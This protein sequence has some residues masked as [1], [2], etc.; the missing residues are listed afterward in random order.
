MDIYLCNCLKVT[1]EFIKYNFK[2]KGHNFVE[3]SSIEQ[4]INNLKC[5]NEATLIIIG[6]DDLD[7]EFIYRIRSIRSNIVI[8]SLFDKLEPKR[9]SSFINTNIIDFID[10]LPLDSTESIEEG[11]KKVLSI[12]YKNKKDDTLNNV[13]QWIKHEGYAEF[14]DMMILKYVYDLIYGYVSGIDAINDITYMLGLKKIP[15]IV[16]TLMVDDF[17]DICINLNNKQRYYTKRT[18]LNLVKKATIDYNSIACS[19]IG[20]EKLIILLDLSDYPREFIQ[21]TIIKISN[22]IKNYIKTN[23]NYTVTLGISNVHDDYKDIWRAYEESFQAINFSFGIGKDIIVQYKD[24]K[25]LQTAKSLNYDFADLEF[26]FFKNLSRNDTKI[27]LE[28]YDR[29]F[30]SLTNK[31]YTKDIIKS[32]LNKFIYNVLQYYIELGLDQKFIS[33]IAMET[34]IHISGASSITSIKEIGRRLLDE[35]SKKNLELTK[36]NIDVSLNAA[37]IFINKYYYKSITLIDVSYV[38]NM[39]AS[40]FSRK[41]KGRYG[42]NFV[43]YLQKIRLE[44]AKELLVES[45]LSIKEVADKVGFNDVAYFSK[46][47]KLNYNA[48]PSHFRNRK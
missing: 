32:I 24:I 3:C 17:W 6:V 18:I 37:V 11:I 38:S 45:S 8:L 48:S 13:T 4:I 28:F 29:L 26:Q 35:L 43:N 47:F 5:N 9:I 41:F 1:R 31:G 46:S 7:T 42:I 34:T 44:K 39:S 27:V 30:N 16:V 20:T 2:N 10:F 40:Y 36:D 14:K 21:E 19:L 25:N 33:N 12:T 22:S 23:S 15:N